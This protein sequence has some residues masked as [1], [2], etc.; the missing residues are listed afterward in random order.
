[1]L[2]ESAALNLQGETI[3]WDFVD[4][5]DSAEITLD[6]AIA[7]AQSA[8][9]KLQHSD[10]YW[11]FELEAD[12]TIPSE[13]ITMMHFLG[14]VDEL[15]QAKIANFLRARQNDNG[16][17]SL[18]T[19]GPG[20]ISC[21]TKVY[22]A[23][24]LAGDSPQRPHMKKAR[25][26]ILAHGGAAKCNVITRILLAMFKQVPWRA[27]PYIPVEIMLLPAW[28]P[29]HLSKVSYW[30]RIVMVPLF[31]L[32]SLKAKAANPRKVDIREL[33]V[34]DPDL[35][36]H[37]FPQR[38]LLNKVFLSLDFLGRSLDPWIP[39]RMR[40]NALR[41]AKN[42]IIARL[43]GEDGLGGIFPAMVSA[44]EAM[45]LLGMPKDHPNVV[46][47]KKALKKLLVVNDRDAYCQ[48]CLSPVWDTG[49]AIL[50]LQEADPVKNDRAIRRGLD[51]L[52]SKQL[53]DEPGDWRIACPDYEGGGGW[54]FE[55]ENPYYPD[56]D[57]TAVVA[58]AMT[59]TPGARFRESAENAARWV[60]VMQ[61]KNGGFGAFDVDNTHYYLNEIPFADH[62]A[63]LDPPTADVS[64]RCAMFLSRML[65][66]HPEYHGTVDRSIEYLRTEQESDG[67]WF[68]RWGTNY[69]YGTWSVLVALEQV[70]IS[71]EDP[72]VRKAVSWLKGK[73]NPD[74]GWGEDNLSY[75]DP[76][77]RG[78]NAFS[79]AF[80]T[81]WAILGLIAAG[82]S[83]SVEV[84]AGV[85]YLLNKQGAD[86]FWKDECF[87]APG[88]PRVFY[89]KYHGYSK[90]FPLWALARYRSVK[91]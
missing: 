90:F 80:Q 77:F 36:Q 38:G 58:F 28:F 89:L 54:A 14:E 44:Y 71:P 37:Y 30:S 24:K 29:F 62:G 63:L 51:W 48:P 8:L 39:G 41:N 91:S 49:L 79:T 5:I 81:A 70:G 86:G 1:M 50:A 12:C 22:Y 61:S 88:F 47:A 10:G 73:Q 6:R 52:I 75:H 68:G 40:E 35:E 76:A 2:E 21:T 34:T 64:A 15:L 19:G 11:V 82:E 45:L 84:E 46:T 87:T 72:I 85:D 16:S 57:D 32:C 56:V 65:D 33:F 26:F 43:N 4:P 7:N 25:Q 74:G 27:V 55:F 13:Y 53:T 23:L 31:V 69:I 59:Q 42:W 17:Y 9:S 60:Q 67:S 20:D 66:R 78:S 3:V 83:D 18:F